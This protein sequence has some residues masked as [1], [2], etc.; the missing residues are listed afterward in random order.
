MCLDSAGPGARRKEAEAGVS[1][2]IA[3]TSPRSHGWDNRMPC[4]VQFYVLLVRKVQSRYEQ[5]DKVAL[6]AFPVKIFSH[7]LADKILPR[8][9]PAV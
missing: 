3:Q 4:L 7:N 5:V 1:E 2:E 8:A 9:S 6:Q